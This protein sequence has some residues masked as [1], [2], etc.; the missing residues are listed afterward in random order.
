MVAENVTYHLSW[1][2]R[3]AV[4]VTAQVLEVLLRAV[5]GIHVDGYG[6]L[7]LH[8]IFFKFITPQ[9]TTTMNLPLDTSLSL[10]TLFLF[11]PSECRPLNDNGICGGSRKFIFHSSSLRKFYLAI[12]ILFSLLFWLL[13]CEC[14]LTWMRVLHMKKQRHGCFH[15]FFAALL[16]WR[17]NYALNL[18]RSYA[19]YYVVPST[20]TRSLSL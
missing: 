2:A 16:F 14:H 17:L 19:N 3:T 15:G 9:R 6:K 4:V 13:L 18:S 20:L 11:C 5:D 12:N 7:V 10:L 1:D 8:S